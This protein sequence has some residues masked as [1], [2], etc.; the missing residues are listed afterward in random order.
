MVGSPFSVQHR[1]YYGLAPTIE[2]GPR[3]LV[4][5]YTVAG[6]GA[7]QDNLTKELMAREMSFVQ[8]MYFNNKLGGGIVT[9]LGSQAEMSIEI[10]NKTQ[11]FLPLFWG[12]DPEFT[13]TFAA[14]GTIIFHFVN[15]PVA[16]QIWTT[17]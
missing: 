5:N 8:G 11:G 1:H 16:P 14:A 7:I 4:K 13:V 10:A 15:I 9:L 3:L 12:P 17:T 6:A 2:E